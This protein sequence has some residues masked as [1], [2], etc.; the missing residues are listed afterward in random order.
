MQ[1]LVCQALKGKTQRD[2]FS[3][4]EFVSTPLSP[5]RFQAAK[6]RGD[7]GPTP[8]RTCLC[9]LPPP[10][11]QGQLE[12][13]EVTDYEIVLL[14]KHIP[15]PTELRLLGSRG[16]LRP[17]RQL[18]AGLPGSQQVGQGQPVLCVASLL[19]KGCLGLDSG[20]LEKEKR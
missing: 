3:C 9:P 8:G 11:A 7:P 10:K 14:L 18:L 15:G 6:G 17:G 16:S 4:R 1:P 20:Y 2:R 12:A 19:E 5:D 13:R